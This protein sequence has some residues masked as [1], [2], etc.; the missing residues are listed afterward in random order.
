MKA[1]LFFDRFRFNWNK[2]YTLSLN[3]RYKSVVNSNYLNL[4]RGRSCSEIF[5]SPNREVREFGRFER[6]I[7]NP[8]NPSVPVTLYFIP[9]SIYHLRGSR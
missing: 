1:V 4:A 7:L 2:K 8:A 9:I 3:K 5:L 6:I